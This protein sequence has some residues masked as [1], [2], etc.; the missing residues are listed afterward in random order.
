MIVRRTLQGGLGGPHAL[1]LA[2][3]PRAKLPESLRVNALEFLPRLRELPAVLG[4]LLEPGLANLVV[5]HAP[6][7]LLHLVPHAVL[8]LPLEGGHALLRVPERRDAFRLNRAFVHLVNLCE[9]EG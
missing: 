7:L 6:H 2:L 4:S 8:A 1:Q 5:P 9:P 3:L